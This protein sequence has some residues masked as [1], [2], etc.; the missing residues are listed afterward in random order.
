MQASRMKN[1][2]VETAVLVSA[3]A[4]VVFAL[5]SV[6]LYRSVMMGTREARNNHVFGSGLIVSP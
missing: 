1:C 3:I 2:T 5:G 4:A 6:F